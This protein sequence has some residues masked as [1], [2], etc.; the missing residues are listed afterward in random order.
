MSVLK[1]FFFFWDLDQWEFNSIYCSAFSS[2]STFVRE[3][4]KK[5]E[6]EVSHLLQCHHPDQFADTGHISMTE[7]QQREQGVSLWRT[8]LKKRVK[9]S[10]LPPI[11]RPR[12]SVCFSSPLQTVYRLRASPRHL[13]LDT[14]S[15]NRKRLKSEEKKTV[16]GQKTQQKQQQSLTA[17]PSN[18]MYLIALRMLLC[19]RPAE[20]K[21]RN[22]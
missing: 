17:F 13:R 14:V 20:P 8:K 5:E 10:E 12:F 21:K 3:R 15:H 18:R 9:A 16:R 11:F 2:G 1:T 6:I 4:E 7:P 22:E 19:E